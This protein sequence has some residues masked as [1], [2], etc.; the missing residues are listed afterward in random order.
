LPIRAFFEN[1]ANCPDPLRALFKPEIQKEAQSDLFKTGV[2]GP[3]KNGIIKM[4]RE[5]NN[6]PQNII[7]VHWK[8]L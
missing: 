6:C 2:L 7:K 1:P 3:E 5:Q 4:V 8:A